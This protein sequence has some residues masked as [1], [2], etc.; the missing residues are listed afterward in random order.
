[1]SKQTHAS[2]S[3][4]QQQTTQTGS[5]EQ[6][7]TFWQAVTILPSTLLGVGILTLPRDVVT[8]ARTGGSVIVV[9]GGLMALL[10]VWVLTRLGQFFS[11]LTVVGYTQKLFTFGGNRRL[12]RWLSLPFLLIG[13]VFWVSFVAVTLRI[14]GEAQRSVVFPHTP[15]WFMLG[16]MLFVSAIVAINRAEVIARLNEFLFPFIVI[17]LLFIVLLGFGNAEW[18]N[19]LPLFHMSWSEFW[20]GMLQGAFAY[21]GVSVMTIFMASYQQPQRAVQSHFLGMG[22]LIVIYFLVTVATLATFAHGEVERLMWPTLELVKSIRFPGFILERIESGFLTIWVAAVFTTLANLLT[23]AVHLISEYIG[24]P[25][26][27]RIWVMLPL[28]LIIYTLA[29]GPED[30]AGAFQFAEYVRNFGIVAACVIFPVLLLAAAI[31][32]RVGHDQDEKQP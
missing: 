28:T 4:Q 11:G 15:L 5:G 18:T 29:M 23:A 19:V 8:V 6:V 20:R 26:S 13:T 2:T 7:F 3:S 16:T 9:V 1:M 27:R 12:G 25:Q 32:R 17:P 30:V 22:I 21:F 10:F 31:R 24:L 14:F